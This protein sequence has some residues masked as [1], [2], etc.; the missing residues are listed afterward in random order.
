MMAA[1]EDEDTQKRGVVSLFYQHSS[2][3]RMLNDPQERVMFAR[4]F[5]AIPLRISA[6]HVCLSNDCDEPSKLQELQ[7]YAM[8]SYGTDA[9]KRTRLHTGKLSSAFFSVLSSRNPS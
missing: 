6:V 7:A 2:T 8:D 1:S 4:L 9:R 3:T 5:D